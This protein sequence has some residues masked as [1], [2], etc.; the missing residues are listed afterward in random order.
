MIR[1]TDRRELQ[2]LGPRASLGVL[3]VEER[4]AV[5][6]RD[7]L[8]AQRAEGVDVAR[9]RRADDAEVR[10]RSRL[11]PPLRYRVRRECARP[12][13]RTWWYMALAGRLPETL[14][15]AAGRL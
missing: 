3:H 5:A 14:F 7:Q 13:L 8:T 10:Q 1:L 4:H 12:G 6:T 2:P 9:H 11:R 15:H